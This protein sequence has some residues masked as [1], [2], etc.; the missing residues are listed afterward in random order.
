L[1]PDEV[2][3]TYLKDFN[4]LLL[5]YQRRQEQEWNR[6]RH[7]YA[8]I[9]NFAGMGAKEAVQPQSL[10]PLYMDEE[11][12]IQPIRNIKQAMQLLKEFS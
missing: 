6:T 10:I 5:G 11:D 7:L 12:K 1:K 3:K 9:R 2:R 8:A 4:L